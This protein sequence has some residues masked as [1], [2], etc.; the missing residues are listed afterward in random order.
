MGHLQAFE[1]YFP[2]GQFV[3]YEFLR[4]SAAPDAGLV[5]RASLQKTP[6]VKRSSEGKIYVRRGAQ[7][8]PLTDDESDSA[9]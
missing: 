3:D 8:W 1:D 7:N 6:D 9:A 5:L 2:L 4:Q